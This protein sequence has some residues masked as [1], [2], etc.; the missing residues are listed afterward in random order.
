MLN[1]LAWHLPC[2]SQGA[3]PVL[4]Q[5]GACTSSSACHA[6]CCIRCCRNLTLAGPPGI[7]PVLDL[8]FQRAVVELCSSCVLSITNMS[9]AQERRGNG[10]QVDFFVGA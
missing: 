4:L 2:R 10:A 1:P 7:M 8:R 9:I 5:W 3:A 6:L